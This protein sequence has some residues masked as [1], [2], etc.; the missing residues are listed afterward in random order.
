MKK[1]LLGVAIGAA[2]V[3]VVSGAGV[4][5]KSNPMVEQGVPV[6]YEDERAWGV[7]DYLGRSH[8]GWAKWE[9]RHIDWVYDLAD[10]N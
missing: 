8:G 9:C 1:V 7:G 5:P 6:C 3:S 4:E 10:P 2:L